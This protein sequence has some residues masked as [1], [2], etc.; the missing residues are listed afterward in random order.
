MTTDSADSEIKLTTLPKYY[1]ICGEVL[2]QQEETVDGVI[3]KVW[4]C[5]DCEFE[6]SV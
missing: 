1:P 5:D 2:R 3:M 4:I 6:M